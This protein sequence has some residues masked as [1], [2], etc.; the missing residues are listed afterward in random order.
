MGVWHLKESGNGTVDEFVDS[1]GTANHGQGGGGT[2]GFV[3]TQITTGKIG[4]AQNFD[5][6]DDRVD[7]S[8]VTND[9]NVTQGMFSVW[10]NMQA[11]P[12]KTRNFLR[13]DYTG[14]I[15]SRGFLIDRC[16]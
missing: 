2:P 14:I 16:S 5:G 8:K 6:S 7:V 10:I 12:E 13:W 3:P 11:F 9:V 15:A 1:S 4:N